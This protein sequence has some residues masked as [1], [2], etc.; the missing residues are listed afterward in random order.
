ML[1][2]GFYCAEALIFT[3]FASD[4]VQ[5]MILLCRQNNYYQHIHPH[6][7]YGEVALKPRQLSIFII[8]VFIEYVH[9][10]IQ[11]EVLCG[12]HNSQLLHFWTVPKVPCET[13]VCHKSRF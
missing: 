5:A 11:F 13:L 12:G 3:L 7:V 10:G 8:D 6:T 2:C 4:S 1:A 9:P